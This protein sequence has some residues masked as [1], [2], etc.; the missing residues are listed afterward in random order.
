MKLTFRQ[1]V[2]FIDLVFMAD[3]FPSIPFVYDVTPTNLN[4]DIL[5]IPA[6]VVNVLKK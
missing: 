5:K 4:T 3:D 1:M 2:E 6:R